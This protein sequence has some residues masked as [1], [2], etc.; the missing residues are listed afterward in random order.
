MPPR[1][2]RDLQRAQ[3]VHALGA[4]SAL[5]AGVTAYG[6]RKLRA[7]LR[8]SGGRDATRSLLRAAGRCVRCALGSSRGPFRGAASA[9]LGGPGPPRPRVP[10]RR[11]GPRALR[12]LS[13]RPRERARARGRVRERDRGAVDAR[14]RPV[15]ELA[16][17]GDRTRPRRHRD[18]LARGER[19]RRRD[20]A[21]RVSRRAPGRAGRGRLSHRALVVLGER[22][23]RP[24]AGAAPRSR[25]AL[26][27]G[28][29]RLGARSR[30]SRPT[31]RC[32]SSA[33]ASTAPTSTAASTRWRRSA[34]ARTRRSRWSTWPRASTASTCA[35][36]TRPPE[37]R[38]VRRSTFSRP[39]SAA[40]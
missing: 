26:R 15:H 21:R 39:P 40:A 36:T 34:C 30:A 13:P 24:P 10:Q 5:T 25:R 14:P 1:H 22:A 29:L 2:S 16:P 8:G 37:R 6:P 32:C 35:T 28:V 31:A 3:R 27:G 4:R 19:R 12:P 7:M 20:P 38:S 18:G 11:C 17:R 23:P 33:R 9:R